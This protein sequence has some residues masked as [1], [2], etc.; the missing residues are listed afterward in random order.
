MEPNFK[1]NTI[2]TGDNL[3]ILRGINADCIDLIYLDP[4]FNSN[5]NYEAPVGSQDAVAS[6]KDMW[7]LDDIDHYE[8]GELEERNE[9]AHA[10]IQAARLTHGKGM[11]AYLIFMAVRL[12]EME[13]VLKPSGSIWLHCDDTA[14]HYLKLLMDAVFGKDRYQNEITWKRTYAHGNTSKF[15]RVAD[16][17][18]FYGQPINKDAVRVP[19]DPE[20]VVNAFPYDDDDG[21][22]KYQS[23]SLTAPG[24]THQNTETWKGYNPSESSRNWGVPFTGAYAD[25]INE[26]IIPGFKDERDRIRRLDMLENAGMILWS[27]NNTPK[28]KWY[29]K[30]NP[31]QVPGNI[32]TDINR[33]GKNSKEATGYPTQKPLALLDR[34]I[35]ASSNEG[36]MVFDPFCGCATALVAA[37]RLNRKWA[38]ID[39]S[40]LA[41]KL[42]DERI[43]KELGLFADVICR[44]DLPRRVD[45]EKLPPYRIHKRTL[46]GKQYGNCAGC[47][48]LF[49]GKIL[50]IDHIVPKAQGGQ[51]HIDN[52]QLLC[53]HCN[54]SKGNRT[55][56]QWRAAQKAERKG[57][58]A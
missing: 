40:P 22:G 37:N 8:H 38:G 17:L 54:Q 4:P 24:P 23:V 25:W 32:W 34:I 10:V 11:M 16:T 56:A 47:G 33:L 57:R 26:N 45:L 49:P 58:A 18:F 6:F 48:V 55:M 46:F 19:L 50:E 14:G 31:G 44:T 36:D 30:A 51:D 41:V 39:L 12:L 1:P 43:R 3:K 7:T 13:R 5:R 9:A 53:S 35:K 15:G 2:W 28:L 21:R 52:L 42:V 27:R 29:S 20:Y